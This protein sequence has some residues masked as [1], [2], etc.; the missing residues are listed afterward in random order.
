MLSYIGSLG[1][2]AGSNPDFLYFQVATTV[3]GLILSIFETLLADAVVDIFA[4]EDELNKAAIAKG[5]EVG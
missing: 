5:N 3:L 4:G 1:L 2:R